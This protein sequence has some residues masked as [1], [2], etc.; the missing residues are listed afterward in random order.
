VTLLPRPLL[1]ERGMPLNLI[2]ET[3]FGNASTISWVRSGSAKNC[4]IVVMFQAFFPDLVR[5][6]RLFLRLRLGR[7]FTFHPPTKVDLD[8]GLK[9]V[10][11]VSH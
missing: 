8:L 7:R 11:E 10:V 1:V 5:L 6:P 9:N 3:A 2:N 4:S